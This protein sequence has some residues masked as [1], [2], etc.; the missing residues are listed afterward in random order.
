MVIDTSAILAILFEE[1][2]ALSFAELIANDS[3]RLMAAPT[4]TE[5]LIVL[6]AKK[7]EAA[8]REFEL[9]IHKT[10]MDIVA[11]TEEQ[12]MLAHFAWQRYGK[13]RHPAALNSGG[14]TKTTT[15]RADQPSKRTAN[16]ESTH[17]QHRNAI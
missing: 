2:E 5:C 13:G 7:G 4:M 1:E 12:A 8:I 16:T 17:I 6:E 9:L 3:T 11:F 10:T 14:R 15:Y